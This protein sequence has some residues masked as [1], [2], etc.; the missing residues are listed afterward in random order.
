M[1]ALD[2]SLHFESGVCNLGEF[3]KERAKNG[4]FLLERQHEISYI[5]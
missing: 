4:V 1:N 5:L 3:F 2:L